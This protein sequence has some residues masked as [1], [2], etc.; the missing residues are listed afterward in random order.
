MSSNPSKPIGP[1]TPRPATSRQPA[2][3]RNSPG[4]RQPSQRE[5]L[6]EAATG[7]EDRTTASRR[8]PETKPR[9]DPV[10][11]LETDSDSESDSSE[12]E[13][14][15]DAQEQAD[16]DGEGGRGEEGKEAE[17]GQAE[18]GNSG[19]ARPENNEAENEPRY[20]DDDFDFDEFIH[21]PP[22]DNAHLGHLPAAVVAAINITPDHDDTRDFLILTSRSRGASLYSHGTNPISQGNSD[23][24]IA[25]PADPFFDFRHI[26]NIPPARRT[27]PP[28]NPN[29]IH[30]FPPPQHPPFNPNPF[31]NPTI[32]LPPPPLQPPPPK[33]QPQPKPPQPS[34]TPN[35]SDSSNNTKRR[36]AKRGSARPPS[37]RKCRRRRRGTHTCC[38]RWG[39]VLGWCEWWWWWLGR[40]VG[41]VWAWN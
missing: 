20:L 32:P 40:A 15:A 13:A 14:W 3:A 37:G 25:R 29:H 38:G 36:S 41:L 34:S 30:I 39:I 6:H 24:R 4:Y 22:P 8:Y 33:Q 19:Q 28:Y 23:H 31:P 9:P 7:T 11:D 16:K 2:R 18:G 17:G 10:P 35:K 21:Y 27:P 1:G 5:H 12:E 26:N